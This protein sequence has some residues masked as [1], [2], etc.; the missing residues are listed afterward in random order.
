MFLPDINIWLALVF[1]W[2]IHHAAANAWYQSSADTCC[3]CRWTQQGFLRLSTNEAVCGKSA[4]SLTDAWVLYDAIMSDPRIAFAEE[5]PG[6]EAFWRAY[7]QGRSFSPKVWSDAYLAAF[8]RAGS[9]DVVT[10]DKGLRQY[11]GVKVIIL[12]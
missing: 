8:A 2:H 5:H 6:I 12:S 10:F 11:G 3:F 9:L 4:V 7:A 1:D